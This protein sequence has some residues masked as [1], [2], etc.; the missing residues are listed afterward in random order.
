MACGVTALVAP[1][2]CMLAVGDKRGPLGLIIRCVTSVT[3]MNIDHDPALV[4]VHRIAH[5]PESELPRVFED[6][7][8]RKRLYETVHQLNLLL[9]EPA[10]RGLAETALKRLGLRHSG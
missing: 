3:R 7:R 5:A 1:L 2:L 4:D 8:R 6:L 9:Q 10:Y